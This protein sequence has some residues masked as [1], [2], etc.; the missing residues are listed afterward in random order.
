MNTIKIRDHPVPPGPGFFPAWPRQTNPGLLGGRLFL[1]F[2]YTDFGRF[3]FV[4]VLVYCPSKAFSDGTT[5]LDM[6]HTAASTRVEERELWSVSSSL[7]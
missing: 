5:S 4:V 2:L 6:W 1:L 3:S 7:L